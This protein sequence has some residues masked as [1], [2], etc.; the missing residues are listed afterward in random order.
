MS[1]VAS[2]QSNRKQIVLTPV[3][4]ARAESTG[5]DARHKRDLS[6]RSPEKQERPSKRTR[7][8]GLTKRTRRDLSGKHASVGKTEKA[9]GKQVA[10][11]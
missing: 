5:S 11:E 7:L 2:A 3:K 1:E 6:A 4:M 9:A 8:A 10:M